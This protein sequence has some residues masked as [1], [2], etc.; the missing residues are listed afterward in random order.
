VTKARNGREG[1]VDV[2]IEIPHGSRS[3]YEFAA[4]ARQEIK[5]AQQAFK[6]KPKKSR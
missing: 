6:K 3:K 5:A 2:V 4:A 1:V